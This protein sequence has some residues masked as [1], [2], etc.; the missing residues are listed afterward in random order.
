MSSPKFTLGITTSKAFYYPRYS[1]FEYLVE[2][3][4]IIIRH[5]IELYK[6][7]LLLI[8][9]SHQSFV[10]PVA[11][12]LEGY[13]GE[14][15]IVSPFVGI[16]ETSLISYKE[17]ELLESALI[18]LSSRF[19]T[20]FVGDKSELADMKNEGLPLKE[21][22]KY[23]QSCREMCFNIVKKESDKLEDIKQ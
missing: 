12:A 5:V 7:S 6:P 21:R 10:Y 2:S 9:L 11:K 1:D 19:P 3:R 20:L 22:T 18:D 13:T 4:S 16:L 14:V 8:D 17:Q 23:A 15:K